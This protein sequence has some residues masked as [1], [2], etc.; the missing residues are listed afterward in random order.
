MF[1]LADDIKRK[2]EREKSNI[3]KKE[4]VEVRLFHCTFFFFL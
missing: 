4:P 1:S 2:R 3:E